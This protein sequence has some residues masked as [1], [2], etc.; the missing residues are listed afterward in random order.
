MKETPQQPTTEL[1]EVEQESI[2][3][4]GLRAG[5]LVGQ[6]ERGFLDGFKESFAASKAV[7]ALSPEVQK[8]LWEARPEMPSGGQ[9]DVKARTFELLKQAVGILKATALDSSRST[10]KWCCS[11]RRTSRPP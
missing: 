11:R 8:S 9:G 6:A 4:A 1:T 2:R 5:A 3:S 10:G 7:K